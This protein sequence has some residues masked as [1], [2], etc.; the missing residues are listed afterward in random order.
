MG[1]LRRL[2]GA[3]DASSFVEGGEPETFTW[4]NRKARPDYGIA[5]SPVTGPDMYGMP[6]VQLFQTG[7]YPAR[8]DGPQWSYEQG[9]GRA[10]GQQWPH[11]PHRE[12]YSFDK[13]GIAGVGIMEDGSADLP[14]DSNANPIVGKAERAG[15]VLPGPAGGIAYYY[16]Q[17]VSQH[18]P[19]VDPTSLESPYS[20]PYTTLTEVPA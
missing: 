1:F 19:K 9:I 18:E 15:W 10:P 3:Q 11:M 17:Y 4:L 2:L 14:V 20:T 8:D 12:Q 13:A 16:G 7:A 6:N 5:Y